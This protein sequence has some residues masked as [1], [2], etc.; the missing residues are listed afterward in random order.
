MVRL[1]SAMM[2]TAME[3]GFDQSKQKAMQI[4]T[5]RKIAPKY[6]FFIL[7][8]QTNVIRLFQEV[9]EV[10]FPISWLLESV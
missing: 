10:S 8:S 7:H 2:N 6:V 4:E 1:K 3:A 9:G 5:I